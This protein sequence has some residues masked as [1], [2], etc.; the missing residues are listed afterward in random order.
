M[1]DAPEKV[2]ES[3]R[4]PLPG[5]GTWVGMCPS[6]GSPPPH[7]AITSHMSPILI[8]AAIIAGIGAVLA[9]W[10]V[11]LYNGL[12]VMRNQY[13]NSF[14]QIDVQLKRRYDLIPNL[15]ETAKKY[16]S[17]ERETLEAVIQARNQASAARQAV[18]ADP[19]DAGGV[20]RLN[21]AEA[22]LTGAMGRFMMLQ[23]SYPDLKAN[24]TMAQLTTELTETENRISYARQAY[25]DSVT[26][27]NNRREMFPSSVFA[28]AFNFT[29][30]QLFEVKSETVRDVV[31]V[32]F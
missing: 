2:A 16:M 11:S 14:S 10:A 30:A 1:D 26:D 28:G 23:E 7:F 25:N 8:T 3:A 24:Q 4:F 9:L 18:A 5:C 21:Q 12:V 6:C 15:V 13:R 29:P 31:K 19:G 20:Q 22:G 32:S 27:Y 17:H